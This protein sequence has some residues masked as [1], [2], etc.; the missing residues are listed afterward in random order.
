MVSSNVKNNNF[1]QLKMKRRAYI[2]NSGCGIG[3]GSSGNGTSAGSGANGGSSTSSCCGST[4]SSSG[5]SRPSSAAS[6]RSVGSSGVCSMFDRSDEMR[7]YVLVSVI[8]VACYVNGLAGDFVHDDIP[9]ITINKDV[10][11]TSPIS[12]VFKNDFWGT[13]MADMN[14]HKSYRPLTIIS[15]R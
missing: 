14:S 8:A 1:R 4:S 12:S 7:I 9:A 15:F 6:K 13:P 3:G 2:M 11:G 10:L 5:G